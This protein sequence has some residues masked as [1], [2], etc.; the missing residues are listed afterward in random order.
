MKYPLTQL[1]KAYYDALS[2]I[3]TVYDGFTPEDSPNNFITIG[4][5]VLVPVPQDSNLF[6]E[7][8]ITFDVNART[9][10]FG[11]KSNSALVDDLLGI[12][13]PDSV[14]GGMADFTMDNQV[15]EDIQTIP[16]LG[17]A[18]N[19]YRTIVRVRAYLTEK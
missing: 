6:T 13:N 14:L 7:C 9:E 8:I 11:F 5:R 2:G 18:D 1:I 4:D 15:I 16:T 10:S 3:T 17:E 19:Q 12:I